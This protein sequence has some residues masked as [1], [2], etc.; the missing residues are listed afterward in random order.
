MAALTGLIIAGGLLSAAGHTEEGDDAKRMSDEE[1]RQLRENAGQ[2]RAAGQQA[3]EE[4]SRRARLVMSRMIAVAAASGAGAVDPTVVKLASGVAGEGELAA[5]MQRYNAESEAQGMEKQ[6][7]SRVRSGA[8][9][10]RASRWRAAG[11]IMQSGY[12]AFGKGR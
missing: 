12:Q 2:T 10:Q 7:T 1:A 9:I 4:E 8:A 11:S 6:A 3:G 5:S